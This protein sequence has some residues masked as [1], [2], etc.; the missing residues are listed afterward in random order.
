MT[1]CA[2]ARRDRNKSKESKEKASEEQQKR[3]KNESQLIIMT[4]SERFRMKKFG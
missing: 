4:L 3:T 2:Q 1:N